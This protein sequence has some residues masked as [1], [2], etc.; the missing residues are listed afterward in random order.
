MTRYGL[1][2]LLWILNFF[3]WVCMS[4]GGEEIKEQSEESKKPEPLSCFNRVSS[5]KR[6]FVSRNICV[7]EP[8]SKLCSSTRAKYI[9]VHL[10]SRDNIC[11][12]V[13]CMNYFRISMQILVVELSLCI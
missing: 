10:I 2:A 1:L 9:Q 11:S 5:P 3:S 7:P 6:S 8:H 13:V 12:H 4:E